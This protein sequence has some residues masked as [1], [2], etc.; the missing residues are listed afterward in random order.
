LQA[1]LRDYFFCPGMRKG[2]T[3]EKSGLEYTQKS[4]PKS[5]AKGE[6]DGGQIK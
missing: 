5:T 2:Q 6:S 4:G 1:R 3:E